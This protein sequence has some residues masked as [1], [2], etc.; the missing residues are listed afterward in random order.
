MRRPGRG[1]TDGP[2]LPEIAAQFPDVE[3]IYRTKINSWH[4]PHIRAAIEAT[5]RRKVIVAGVTADFCAGLPAKSLAAAGYDV[6]LVL[7]ASGTNSTT[8]QRATIANLTQGGVQVMGWIATACELQGDWVRQDTG[9]Q[10]GH[11]YG[12]HNPPWSFLQTILDA[13]A[14]VPA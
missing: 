10:L 7:D 2:L 1:G 13:H 6:R 11:I 9:A 4:D 8:V 5:G 14:A 3:P 12:E